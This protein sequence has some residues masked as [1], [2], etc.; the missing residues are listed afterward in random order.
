MKHRELLATACLV[1]GMC[2]QASAQDGNK[3]WQGVWQSMLDGQPGAIVTLA[4]DTGRLGGTIVLNMIN[5]ENG[6]TRVFESE[7][8]VLV[9]PSLNDKT[10][11]FELKNPR[12]PTGMMDFTMMLKPD[13]TTTLHC[14]NC[15][16]APVVEL[17]KEW[18]D[19]GPR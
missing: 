2:L 17:T 11:T 7:A 10:L 16:G 18:R 4:K 12:T 8:H 1:A 15:K 3:A 13:G 6:Q 19:G 14:T 5:N 9:S